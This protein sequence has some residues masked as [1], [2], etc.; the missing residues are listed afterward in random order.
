MVDFKK[1]IMFVIWALKRGRMILK[2]EL[3]FVATHGPIALYKK[4]Q[5]DLAINKVCRKSD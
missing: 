2:E 4:L 3:E 1:P 5:N